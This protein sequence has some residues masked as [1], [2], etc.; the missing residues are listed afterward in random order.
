MRSKVTILCSTDFFWGAE[1]VDLIN[2]LRRS[3]CEG[4]ILSTEPPHYFPTNM[5]RTTL[6]ELRALLS[7]FEGVVAIRTPTTDVNMFSR[8]PYVAKASLQSIMEGISLASKLNPD[9]VIIRPSYRP[10]EMSSYNLHKLKS[11][12]QKI[13]RNMYAAFELLNPPE[14]TSVFDERTA[15]IS[16][17]GYRHAKQRVVGIA[18]EVEGPED[19]RLIPGMVNVRYI[20]LY[21]R[22]RGLMDSNTLKKVVMRARELRERII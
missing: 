14:D 19:M 1:P 4:V 15:L 13:P 3:G 16:V 6:L 7:R 9:F 18:Y 10:V 21:P 2:F 22:K 8:N 5:T 12:M 17:A 20:L 11:L